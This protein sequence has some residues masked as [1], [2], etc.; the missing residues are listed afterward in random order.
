M[1]LYYILIILVVFPG[2]LL[3]KKSKQGY[4]KLYII[5]VFALLWVVSS[6]RGYTVGGDLY[7]YIRL[8]GDI[9]LHSIKNI[10]ESYDKYGYLFK[11]YIKI[12]SYISDNITFLLSATSLFN[13]GIVCWFVYKRSSILWLSFLL[14]LTLGYYTNTFNSVRSSMALA[15]GIIGVD[16]LISKKN[17]RAFIMF[18]L[19]LEIHKTILPI[20]LLFALRSKRYK[21]STM[22]IS[23]LTSMIVANYLGIDTMANL[24][25]LYDSA[26]AV[27]T[28]FGGRGYNL[29]ILD[30]IITFSSYYLCKYRI[31]EKKNI[32]VNILWLATCLQCMAPVF[33]VATRISYFFTFYSIVL[34]PNVILD[35]FTKKSKKLIFAGI[36]ILCLIY[37][38]LTIMTPIDSTNTN[39]QATIPYYFYFE[40]P[41]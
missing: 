15:I 19:A 32:L 6:L 37:F 12:C 8:F 20:F 31:T 9:S 22:I 14:Y 33:S 41:Q 16:S 25:L 21:I 39:S 30:I 26:Y 13:I 18:V 1:Y 36:S 35:A 27:Q 23:I 28:D 2:L 34:I 7:N 3:H 11:L 4:K 10:F 24:I 38:K 29:L 17:L 40:R 5:Y